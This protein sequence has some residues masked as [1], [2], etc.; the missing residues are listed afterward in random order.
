LEPTTQGQQLQI[1]T[2]LA[3]KQQ[4]QQHVEPQ[5]MEEQQFLYK[6]T[7]GTFVRETDNLRRI[8]LQHSKLHLLLITFKHIY[9]SLSSS[10]GMINAAEVSN[11][12]GSGSGLPLLIQRSVAR[13]ISLINVIGINKATKSLIENI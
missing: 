9:F 12:S 7:S 10:G 11:Y 6:T 3:Q 2:H 13:Q 1:H 4:L 5:P 8:S